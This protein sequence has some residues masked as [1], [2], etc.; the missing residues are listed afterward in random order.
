MLIDILIFIVALSILVVVHEYGHYWM[1]RKIGVRVLSFSVGFGKPLFK[2]TRGYTNFYI[3]AIPLG[4]YVKLLDRREG[5]VSPADMPEEFSSKPVLNRIAVFAAGPIVNLLFAFVLY[6]GIYLYGSDV[7]KPIIQHVTPQ[8]LGES[9]GFVEGDEIVAIDGKQIEDWESVIW[10]LVDRIGNTG[11]IDVTILSKGASVPAMKQIPI[12]QFLK[13]QAEINP[14]KILGI[15]VEP[16]FLPIVGKVK[17]GSPA[18]TAG[19]K[20]G[21][22]IIFVNAQL[23]A[24]WDSWVAVIQAN[25]DKPLSTVINRDGK[26]VTLII[27]P[28]LTTVRGKQVSQVGVGLQIPEDASS[29]LQFKN[30]RYGFFPAF[31][32]AGQ[33]T[34]DKIILTVETIAKMFTGLVSVKNLSGP[35]TI[36]TLAADSAEAG[37]QPFI[38][39]LAYIS[40]SLGVLN[41]LPVPVLDGGHILYGVIEWVTRR[42]LSDKVQ[43]LGLNIGLGFLFMLMSIAFYNDII[44]LL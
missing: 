35:V 11:V 4:G 23:I 12:D 36:A 9:A 21:D 31:I 27:T 41:L 18:D 10:A 39:F 19:L 33:A 20:I 42:P 6:W 37:F 30:V 3:S 16:K 15:H 32:H 8:S 25:T 40:I 38:K 34:W 13:D 24:D 26:Q 22:H 17:A 28:K 1:A 5:E 44:R 29:K 2:W 7:L 14:L 43:K